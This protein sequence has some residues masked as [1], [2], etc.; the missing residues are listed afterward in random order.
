MSSDGNICYLRKN[1]VII[2]NGID[3]HTCYTKGRLITTDYIEVDQ[4]QYTGEPIYAK[5]KA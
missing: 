1:A 5:V 3:G 2:G 4:A